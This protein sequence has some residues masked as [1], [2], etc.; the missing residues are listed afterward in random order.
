MQGGEG[1]QL[2]AV[3]QSPGASDW[4]QAVHRCVA[5]PRVG[6]FSLLPISAAPAPT[7]KRGAA[8]AAPGRRKPRVQPK[9]LFP[10]PTACY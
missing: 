3:Q 10:S 4:Q 1:A 5:G 9:E 2:R 6:P 8:R 7:A